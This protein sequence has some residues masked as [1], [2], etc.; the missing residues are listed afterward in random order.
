MG[1][2]P[3][4]RGKAHQPRA[5]RQ[6]KHQ[7]MFKSLLAFLTV[8]EDLLQSSFCCSHGIF[9]QRNEISTSKI[10]SPQNI[11]ALCVCLVRETPVGVKVTS[12]GWAEQPRTE[13]IRVSGGVDG[14]P[15]GE[16]SGKRDGPCD[17]PA[18]TSSLN[19]PAGLTRYSPLEVAEEV[20]KSH[21]FFRFGDELLQ[22][23]ID[24]VVDVR[25]LLKRCPHI[26]GFTI[27]NVLRGPRSN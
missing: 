26:R 25:Q 20:V 12:G 8:Q 10:T 21:A 27:A 24:A 5:L 3:C 2:R 23:W 16:E 6:V 14:Y 17:Y 19:T 9:G 4:L 13:L 22:L 1:G 18:F 11:L 7:R 15:R